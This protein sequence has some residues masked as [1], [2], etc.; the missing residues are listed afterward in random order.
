MFV[1]W[2]PPGTS[3]VFLLVVGVVGLGG[4]LQRWGALLM[5]SYQGAR[6][7]QD[8]STGGADLGPR[9]RLFA[10]LLH[11]EITLLSPSTLS[12]L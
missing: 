3:D 4:G 5:P 11:C 8:S 2:P 12:S 7:H 1:E 10:G 9:L 6:C